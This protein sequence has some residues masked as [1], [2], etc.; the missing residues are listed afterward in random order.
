MSDAMERAALDSLEER[1]TFLENA[2]V[3]EKIQAGEAIAANIALVAFVL[4]RVDESGFVRRK[5]TM[6]QLEIWAK[7]F[8]GTN[9]LASQMMRSLLTSIQRKGRS[10]SARRAQPTA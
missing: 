8:E 1:V 4:D 9:P 2:I 7:S 3:A 5:E 6:R 10:G